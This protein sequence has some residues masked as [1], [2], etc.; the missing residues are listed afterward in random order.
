[1]PLLKL[2][3]SFQLAEIIL[4]GCEE[5]EQAQRLTARGW[6]SCTHWPPWLVL[7]RT[8]GTLRLPSA[9]KPRDAVAL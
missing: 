8:T 9:V 1:M 6:G 5:E 2:I 3:T 4:I 7:P